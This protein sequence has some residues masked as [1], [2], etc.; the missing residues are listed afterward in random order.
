MPRQLITIAFVLV[1][2]ALTLP[3]CTMLPDDP[4]MHAKVEQCAPQDAILVRHLKETCPPQYIPQYC[5]G[6]AVIDFCLEE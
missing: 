2:A 3:A 5:E 4:W 6:L 1:V